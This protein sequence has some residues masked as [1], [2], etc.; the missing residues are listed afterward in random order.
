[1]RTYMYWH[2]LLSWVNQ[3]T[4]T[5]P[6]LQA[7][8]T[9][10][11]LVSTGALPTLRNRIRTRITGQ[12]DLGQPSAYTP[13]GWTAA[14]APPAPMPG[15]VPAPAPAPMFD[16]TL[17][18]NVFLGIVALAF[19]AALVLALIS[20]Y[21]GIVTPGPAPAPGAPIV[22]PAPVNPAPGVPAPG[23]AK[24][25]AGST[26]KMTDEGNKCFVTSPSPWMLP[27]GTTASYNNNPYVAGEVVPAGSGT[28]WG[29]SILSNK[30]SQQ[31]PAAQD[32]Q[33]SS[34][35]PPLSDQ[36]KEPAKAAS[37]CTAVRKGDSDKLASVAGVAG[38][39]LTVETWGG[40]RG[41]SIVIIPPGETAN[42][43]W[44]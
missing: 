27:A 31:A 37:V 9:A 4:R 43:D 34:A 33:T 42:R 10:L 6:E 11:G 21:R 23:T 8:A 25:P 44:Q 1:M 7:A 15:P 14:A 19:L 3:P 5:L 41:D 30:S 38:E 24:L 22:A 16:R 40:Q 39:I 36:P 28:V 32:K 18:T 2:E 29:C 13:P 26:I 12:P 20:L 35:S 17:W